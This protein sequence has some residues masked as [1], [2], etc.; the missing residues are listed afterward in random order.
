MLIDVRPGQQPPR[1][2]RSMSTGPQ[3]LTV[4]SDVALNPPPAPHGGMPETVTEA[5]QSPLSHCTEIEMV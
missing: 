2:W 4:T 3:E 5:V 1:N